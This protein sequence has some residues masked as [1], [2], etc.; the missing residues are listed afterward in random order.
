M[1]RGAATGTLATG[2]TCGGRPSM[3]P[4]AST[5]RWGLLLA[6]PQAH[7]RDLQGLGCL[8]HRSAVLQRVCWSLPFV[9][10]LMAGTCAAMLGA[11]S[12]LWE[13][14]CVHLRQ[15]S[16]PCCQCRRT[17]TCCMHKGQQR[18]HHANVLLSR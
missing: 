15:M 17:G 6:R 18:Q 10:L 2:R 7:A 5:C 12:L 4:R 14:L 11:Q 16:L 8:Q 1:W 9:R 13:A 3:H